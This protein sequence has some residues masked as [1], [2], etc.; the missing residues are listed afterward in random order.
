M[1]GA[2]LSVSIVSLAVIDYHC[3]CLD[4]QLHWQVFTHCMIGRATKLSV[5]LSVICGMA[6]FELLIQFLLFHLPPKTYVYL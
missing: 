6:H 4:G 2:Y 5:V 3:N 1:I